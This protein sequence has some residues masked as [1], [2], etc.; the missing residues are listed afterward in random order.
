MILNPCK[1]HY[2]LLEGHVL[3]DYISLNG[4][5][6]ESS[7]NETLGVILDNDLKV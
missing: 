6:I 5:E 2:I 1:C 3:I 4:T 7:R